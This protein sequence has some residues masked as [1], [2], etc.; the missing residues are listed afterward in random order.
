ME[1]RLGTEVAELWRLSGAQKNLLLFVS[2]FDPERVP[3][4]ANAPSAST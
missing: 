4:I 3:P 2:S 1:N